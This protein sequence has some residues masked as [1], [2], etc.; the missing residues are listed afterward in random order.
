MTSCRVAWVHPARVSS[1]LC[2]SRRPATPRRPETP[3]T[4]DPPAVFA[5][6]ILPAAT[7]HGNRYLSPHAAELLWRGGRGH[8]IVLPPRDPARPRSHRLRPPSGW[9]RPRD[10]QP[11]PPARRFPARGRD[12]PHPRPP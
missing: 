10:P 3:Y 5:P 2:A 11:P 7:A 4:G 1:D 8:R 6:D 12:G 9:S